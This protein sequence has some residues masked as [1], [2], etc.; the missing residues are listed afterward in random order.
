[1]KWPAAISGER[2]VLIAGSTGQHTDYE[3]TVDTAKL[4]PLLPQEKR[5]WLAEMAR[6][7]KGNAVT[8]EVTVENGRINSITGDVPVPSPSLHQ[9]RKPGQVPAIPRLHALIT[10]QFDYG[11]R[12]GVITVPG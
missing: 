2:P 5:A 11:K 3:I 7:S 6:E 12:G 1:V 4:S 10:M 9:V 8:L